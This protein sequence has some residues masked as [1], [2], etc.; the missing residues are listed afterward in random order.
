LSKSKPSVDFVNSNAFACD[1]RYSIVDTE[2]EPITEDIA[3]YLS[4]NSDGDIAVDEASYP[5][6]V[7]VSLQIRAITDYGTPVFKPLTI[8]EICGKQTLSNLD[9]VYPFVAVRDFTG[10][11]LSLTTPFNDIM[12]SNAFACPITFSLVDNAGEPITDDIAS[13]LSINEDGLIQVDEATYPGGEVVRIQVK[14]ITPNTENVEPFYQRI[15]ITEI[16]GRQSHTVT[17]IEK[18][19]DLKAISEKPGKILSTTKP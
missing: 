7:D 5:G 15:V 14:S 18:V 12:N 3:A 6:G 16:C 1:V 9:T 19:Y 8:S 10:T 2:G 11:R 17:D 4:I 13:F